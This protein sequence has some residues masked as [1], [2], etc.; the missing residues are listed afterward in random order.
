V[1]D[2]RFLL[3]LL[4]DVDTGA[5]E[6]IHPG[7]NQFPAALKASAT[8]DPDSPTYSE[9]M[10]GEDREPFEEAMVN[11]ISDLEKHNTWT[12]IL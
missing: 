2:Y 8:K 9:V 5:L 12:T 6:G 3:A 11:E 4:T 7:I 10:T 1:S